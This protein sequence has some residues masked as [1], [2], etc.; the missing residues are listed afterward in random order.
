MTTPVAAS[1]HAVPQE[2]DI[3][4]AGERVRYLEQGSGPAILLIHGFPSS[5]GLSFGRLFPLLPDHSRV[6][7]IDLAG[8][9]WS[10]RRRRGS[11]D[12]RSQAQRLLRV[13]DE[14]KVDRMV[15]VG[16]S[17]GGAVAQHLAL[18]A[19][20]RVD[21]LVLLAALDAGDLT[22]GRGAWLFAAAVGGLLLAAKLP[23]LGPKV[24]LKVARPH[25]GYGADWTAQN[26]LAATAFVPMRG[27]VRCAVKVISDFARSPRPD[28]SAITAPTLVVSGEKD[29]TVPPRVG[30]G[31][32]AKIAGARHMT[33]AGCPHGLAMEQPQAVADCIA[34]VLVPA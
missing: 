16:T 13:L 21:Q 7:A 2:L 1:P 14:L 25:S 11:F 20:E 5:G 32:A 9:G 15:V 22:D 3:E 23:W 8:L 31:I 18:L 29:T 10:E 26:A 17:L 24:R 6:V 34:S 27:T 19:P 30:V 12:P 33:L 4:V 28:I